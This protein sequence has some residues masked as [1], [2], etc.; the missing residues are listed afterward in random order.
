MADDPYTD[1]EYDDTYK[2]VHGD[3]PARD[4]YAG[5]EATDDTFF[6]SGV[7]SSLYPSGWGIW[8]AGDAVDA[9]AEED[10]GEAETAGKYDTA[11]GTGTDDSEDSWWDVGL[12]G[13][14][15]VVGVALF[16]FPEPATSALG[17]GLITLGVI[18]WVVDWLA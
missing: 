18:A 8:P 12:I 1:D 15:L 17:I 10:R 14:L 3:E 9:T 4:Q 13:T 16:L 5:E 6:P 2:E 11:S 7:G